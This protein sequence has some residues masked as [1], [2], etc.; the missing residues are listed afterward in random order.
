MAQL[1]ST[2]PA[3][4]YVAQTGPGLAPGGGPGGSPVNP[5]FLGTAEFAP[6]IHVR[7]EFEPVFNDLG[8][9]RIAFDTMY[10]SKEGFSFMDL[11]RWNENLFQQL[12]A[13]PRSINV[14]PNDPEDG[15]DFNGDIGTLMI[16]EGL[17]YT[18][19]LKFPYA[20]KL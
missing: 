3:L 1:F 18:V 19:F 17:A 4:I 14:N 9:S 20:N 13:C 16:Q 15:A 6:Q 5:G 10:E 7:R 12:A 8:G 2:A 11:T